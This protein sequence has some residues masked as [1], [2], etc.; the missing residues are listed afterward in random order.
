MSNNETTEINELAT[1]L[2][3][4]SPENYYR[5]NHN[6]AKNFSKLQHLM[7][8]T[9]VSNQL[10]LL[11][12]YAKNNPSDINKANSIGWT[13][14]H[15]ACYGVAHYGLAFIKLLL[16]LGANVN[17]GDHK[18]TTPLMFSVTSAK[19]QIDQELV[20]LLLNYGANINKSNKFGFTALMMAAIYYPLDCDLAIIKLLLDHG[21]NPNIINSENKTFMH[22]ITIKTKEDREIIAFLKKI[23]VQKI[24]MDMVISELKNFFSNQSQIQ[25]KDNQNSQQ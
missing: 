15:L 12:I 13:A 6:R 7:T 17:R 14:L 25:S 5:I 22:Y 10:D 18:G 2:A 11:M 21:A 8:K 20:K 4:Y 24:C 19:S 9:K 1:L 3:D 16:D 23:H